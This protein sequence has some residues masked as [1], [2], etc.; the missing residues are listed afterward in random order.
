MPMRLSILLFFSLFSRILSILFLN[1]VDFPQVSHCVYHIFNVRRPPVI[2]SV[3]FIIL[4]RKPLIFLKTLLYEYEYHPNEVPSPKTQ[5]PALLYSK[6]AQH[7]PGCWY[8]S[9]FLHH[10]FLPFTAAP[11][12]RPDVSDPS[13]GAHLRCPPIL[14]GRGCGVI[15]DVHR[16]SR[17]EAA[18]A[19]C[20]SVWWFLWICWRV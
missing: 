16:S 10:S 19:R 6:S 20:Q 15:L 2:A 7:Y 4:T 1:I 9:H 8:S 17:T 5:S 13:T 18:A 14:I 11:L 12:I 3:C